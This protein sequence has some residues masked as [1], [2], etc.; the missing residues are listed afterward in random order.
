[1]QLTFAL[2]IAFPYCFRGRITCYGIQ[3]ANVASL[4]KQNAN[5]ILGNASVDGELKL[6]DP[7]QIGSIVVVKKA[8]WDEVGIVVKTNIW[9]PGGNLISIPGQGTVERSTDLC[10]NATEAQRKEYFK[11]ALKHGT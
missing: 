10:Y 4:Q 5:T 2:R 8:W 11:Q 9:E 7:I 6:S 1:V 3:L